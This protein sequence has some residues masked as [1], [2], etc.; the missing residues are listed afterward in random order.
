MSGYAGAGCPG[1]GSAGQSGLPE[2]FP[3]SALG[4][5]RGSAV[6]AV[7]TAGNRGCPSA[8]TSSGGVNLSQSN[9]AS[10]AGTT[11]LVLAVE[12]S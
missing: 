10:R 11:D 6:F 8:E 12:R 9:V 4:S 3:L 7:G 5:R 1:E 2:G